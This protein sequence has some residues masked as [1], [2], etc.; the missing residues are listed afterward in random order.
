MSDVSN[1]R[2]DIEASTRAAARAERARSD[3]AVIVRDP[4]LPAP[5]GLYDPASEQD[6]CGVGFIADMKNRRSHEIVA[7]GLQILLNL[8]HRGAVG[9]DPKMGDGCGILVQIPHRFFAA[10]CAKLG[11]WLPEEGEYGV[12]HLFLPRDP[13][14]FRLVEEIVT[15]AIADEGLQ[16]LGWRDVPVDSSDLGE[17][18]K[19]TEPRQRHVFVG[20]GAGIED[21]DTFERRLFLARKVIS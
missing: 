17:S 15:K 4:A 12:G 5:Q 14:G 9:A 8:D 7:Q 6:S 18:V 19:A 16:L 21:E 13:E 1:K 3:K 20:R 11:I 2:L 10:E